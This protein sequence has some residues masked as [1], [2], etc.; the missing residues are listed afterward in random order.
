M[1]GVPGVE[2]CFVCN[3]FLES[4]ASHGLC[5]PCVEKACQRYLD[6]RASRPLTETTVLLDER[7]LTTLAQSQV[8]T[9]KLE[10]GAITPEQATEIAEIFRG[11]WVLDRERL[12]QIVCIGLAVWQERFVEKDNRPA[13]NARRSHYN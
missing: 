5:N 7:T 12:E 3:G 9:D 1:T 11:L 8:L 10:S 4:V 6:E 2:V 13:C